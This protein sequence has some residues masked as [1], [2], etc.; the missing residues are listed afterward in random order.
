MRERSELSGYTLVKRIGAG[1]MSTV[2]EA[3]DPAGERVALKRMSPGLVG[4][5]QARLRL[6]RE[7]AM[8][9]RVSSPHVSQILDVEFDDDVFI[10]TEL[11]DGPTLEEE[12]ADNGCFA[13]QDLIDLATELSQALHAVHAAGVLHRDIKPSNV[14]IG[15]SGVVL[16]DF[17]ISQAVGATR[18]TQA[19]SIA[20]T[21]GYVDPRII[22]G[23]EPDEAADWWAL[24]AVIG[25]AAAGHSVF[26]GTPMA[27]M[28]H[29]LHGQP[30]LSGIDPHVAHIIAAAL[31]PDLEFRMS[32]DDLID[33]LV[34]PARFRDDD[35]TRIVPVYVSDDVVA[36]TADEPRVTEDSV[37][38]TMVDSYLPDPELTLES[39]V[40]P[41]AEEILRDPFARLP[42]YRLLWILMVC[43]LA[44]LASWNVAIAGGTSALLFF[45]FSIVGNLWERAQYRAQRGKT[46]WL[47]LIIRFPF[48][49]LHAGL[50]LIVGG[51][52]GCLAGFGTAWVLSRLLDDSQ[53]AGP[54][55]L[56]MLSMLVTQVLLWRI[57]WG[58]NARV[59][60][61]ATIRELTPSRAY[62]VFWCAIGLVAVVGAV[63]MVTTMPVGGYQ[64][65]LF[66]IYSGDPQSI[67]FNF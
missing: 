51:A 4:D 24:A 19:G 45:I 40:V 10:V 41:E 47:P 5:P 52:V 15:E 17:G 13:G 34:D 39:E 48:V 60:W 11:I 1:G 3:I 27:I 31:D 58:R 62:Y 8:M 56:F 54:H 30:D 67:K 20:H 55:V 53:I 42:H 65:D 29:V 21:P 14:M 57:D 38:P 36:E 12:V 44:I 9:Q 33:A 61:N 18:L 43:S 46:G 16:I 32:F 35:A 7:V 25:F 28:N 37:P 26:H 66:G 64:L 59:G 49:A 6:Q 22:A 23:S 63:I 2:Y 50:L